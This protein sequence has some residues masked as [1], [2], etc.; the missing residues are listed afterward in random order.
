MRRLRFYLFIATAALSLCP[1]APS[2]AQYGGAGGPGMPQ[3]GA[4][5]STDQD[6]AKKKKRDEE[7]GNGSAP[8]PARQGRFRAA[9]S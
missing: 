1:A 4:P 6:D 9:A 3:H 8:L 2:L 7:F 5:P